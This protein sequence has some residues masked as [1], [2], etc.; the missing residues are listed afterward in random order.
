M[1][2]F[3]TQAEWPGVQR[4]VS[5]YGMISSFAILIFWL[6][7]FAYTGELAYDH[8]GLPRLLDAPA[9]M[10]FLFLLLIG[11]RFVQWVLLQPTLKEKNLIWAVDLSRKLIVCYLVFGLVVLGV[12]DVWQGIDFPRI[13]IAS[14]AILFASIFVY[15]WLFLAILVLR[16]LEWHYP[17]KRC[18]CQGKTC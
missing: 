11:V 10:A 17:T 13:L 14:L 18:P 4:R 8:S 16:L 5:L 3:P 9:M 6:C 7:H 1:K 12:D 15:Y 2:I